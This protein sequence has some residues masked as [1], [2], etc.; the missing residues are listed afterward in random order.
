MTEIVDG[1]LRWRWSRWDVR[2]ALRLDTLNWAVRSD[3]TTSVGA[4][5]IAAIISVSGLQRCG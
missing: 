2:D 3:L 5:K 4:I 1:S